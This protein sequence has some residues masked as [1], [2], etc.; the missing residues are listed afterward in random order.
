VGAR[1]RVRT[2]AT[3][4][5]L[6]ELEGKAQAQ[7]LLAGPLECLW[8]EGVGDQSWGLSRPPGIKWVGQGMPST[9]PSPPVPKVLSW[10]A[11]L[12]W[13]VNLS[14]SLPQLPIMCTG[15]VWPYFFSLP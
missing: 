1:S 13:L 6:G 10:Q 7:P 12:F 2:H 9:F 3:G 14:S 4:K 8:P 11:C 15:P 5:A